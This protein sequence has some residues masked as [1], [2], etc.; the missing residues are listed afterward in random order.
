M[1]QKMNVATRIVQRAQQMYPPRLNAAVNYIGTN[2]PY[3]K[4]IVDSRTRDK[5]ILQML[6]QDLEQ[7]AV[8][9]PQTYMK[10]Q[11]RLQVLQQRASDQEP[12]PAPDQFEE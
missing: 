6:P 9:D 12:L 1:R 11:E 5:Q 10:T 2:P 7:L 4:K 3:G 8:T